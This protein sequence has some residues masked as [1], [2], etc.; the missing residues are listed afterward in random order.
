MLG[1]DFSFYFYIMLANIMTYLR[2]VPGNKFYISVHI[3]LSFR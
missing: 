3:Q 2:E 1:P